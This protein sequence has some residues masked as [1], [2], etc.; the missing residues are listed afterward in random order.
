VGIEVYE[1][2]AACAFMVEGLS[3]Y[4]KAREQNQYLDL[5]I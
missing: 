3:T 1:E 5:N 2:N 4:K